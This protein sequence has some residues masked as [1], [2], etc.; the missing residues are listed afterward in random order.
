LRIDL[1]YQ[2]SQTA[3]D[4]RKPVIGEMH[5]TYLL[6]Q[7]FGLIRLL[8]SDKGTNQI[9]SGIALGLILGFSP[10]FSLQSVLV[11]IILFFFRVQIGAA[12][13]AAFFFSLIAYLLDP[14]CHFLGAMILERESLRPIFTTLYNMP[15]VPFTR[16]YNSIVMGSGLLAILL[17]PF[18]YYGSKLLVIKYR[19]TV[20]AR[21]QET[22]I[23]K[24]WKSTTFYNWYTKYEELY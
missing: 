22:K 16:F 13:I 24:A 18:V 17:A 3:L 11:F 20:V 21:F 6:K 5:M 12:F 19:A 7:I 8:N 9:A 1:D 14:V 4:P 15:I 2:P 10:L 23:W